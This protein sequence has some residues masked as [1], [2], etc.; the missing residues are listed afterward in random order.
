MRILI[1]DDELGNRV[2]MR[3]LLKP[4]GECEVVENG[5]EAVD[6]FVLRLED[7]KPFDLICLDIMMPILDGMEALKKIRETEQALS[8]KPEQEVKILVISALDKTPD[9]YGAFEGGCTDYIIKPITRKKLEVKLK[10]Y[11]FIP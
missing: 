3:Q 2:L 4:Y 7:A 9:I 10:D 5:A 1:A 8:I 11:K 6:L